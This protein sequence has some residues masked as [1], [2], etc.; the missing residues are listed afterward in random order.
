[1]LFAKIR[2]NKVFCWLAGWKTKLYKHQAHPSID[3][4]AETRFRAQS[5]AWGVGSSAE[6]ELDFRHFLKEGY[7]VSRANEIRTYE[8]M[9]MGV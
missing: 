2:A 9:Q 4:K 5:R 3:C 6:W 8:D 7:G 1:M